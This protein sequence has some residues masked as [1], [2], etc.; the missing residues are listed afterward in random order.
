MVTE[1]A[2]PSRAT[3]TVAMP[4]CVLA[5]QLPRNSSPVVPGLRRTKNHTRITATIATAPP[6]TTSRSSPEAPALAGAAADAGRGWCSGPHS[7]GP[8]YAAGAS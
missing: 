2:S 1:N 6:T 3:T 4:C 7:P 5:V 8:P